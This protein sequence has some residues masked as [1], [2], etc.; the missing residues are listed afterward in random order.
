MSITLIT[1][2][3]LALATKWP[4]VTIG[5]MDLSDVPPVPPGYLGGPLRAIGEH[6]HAQL[7]TIRNLLEPHLGPGNKGA[8]RG[9]YPEVRYPPPT[10]HVSGPANYWHKDCQSGVV[11][12]LVV[13]ANRDPTKVRRI[14]DGYIYKSIKPF[15]IVLINNRV[16]EHMGPHRIEPDRWF[17]RLIW[18]C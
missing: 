10:S 11:D 15:D 17:C 4:V 3:E 9:I 18:N 7:R 12:W 5:R 8:Q 6:L 2:E 1:P 16:C 14:K 13:W